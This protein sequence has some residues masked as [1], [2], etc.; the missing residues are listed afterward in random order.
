MINLNSLNLLK[1]LFIMKKYI[2]TQV[3]EMADAELIQ[4]I[5]N[6]FDYTIPSVIFSYAEYKRRN[7]VGNDIT[8]KNIRKFGNVNLMHDHFDIDISVDKW[9]KKA[10]T[11]SYDELYL[12]LTGK[13]DIPSNKK[14]NPLTTPKIEINNIVTASAAGRA[15]QIIFAAVLILDLITIIGIV[16]ATS[17]KDL[18]TIKYTCIILGIIGLIC[19]Y[20]L[21]YNLMILFKF[22][23]QEID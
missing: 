19:N 18:D 1:T 11:D 4:I 21:T 16:V 17:S 3:I 12:I 10:G 23:K 14:I 9:C 13:K 22:M 8:L 2:I 15:L 20:G 5:D 7:L 6:H